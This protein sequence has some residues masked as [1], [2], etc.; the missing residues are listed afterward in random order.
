MYSIVLKCFADIVTTEHN[1]HT[2]WNQHLTDAASA[3]NEHEQESGK[4]LLYQRA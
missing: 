2:D 1:I 4:E 3:K